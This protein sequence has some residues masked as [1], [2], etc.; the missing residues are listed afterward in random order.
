[1]KY[2]CLP[3]LLFA[4]V[5][6]APAGDPRCCP[7]PS[8][9][10]VAP[11][12]VTGQ[13]FYVLD[14]L[15]PPDEKKDERPKEYPRGWK[16]PT[17]EEIKRVSASLQKRHNHRVK[18][19][20][21]AA[22][23]AFDTRTFG[24]TGPV[25][26]QKNCGSCW[27][28]GTT[29]QITSAFIKAGYAKND[30]SFLLSQ[31][32]VL[33]CVPSG[34][35]NGDWGTTVLEAAKAKGLPTETDYGPYLARVAACKFKAG[36][37]LYQIADYGWCT[38][39]Q[40]WG[41]SSTQ[42]IKNCIVQ[43]GQVSTAV[44]ANSDWDSY[45]TGTLP[46]RKLTEWDVNHEVEICGW[47]DTKTVAGAAGKGAWLVKNSWSQAWGDKGYVWIGY[48]SHQI[49]TGAAWATVAALPPPPGPTP[50]DPP[51]PPVPPSPGKG[52][53]GTITKVQEYK[54]GVPVGPEKLILGAPSGI[55]LEAELKATWFDPAI[56]ADVMKLVN[57]F[58]EK[59]GLLVL[60]ADALKIATDLGLLKQKQDEEAEGKKSG[61]REE[62]LW[63]L[64]A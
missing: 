44:A 21:V 54:D 2:L 42:D 34:G 14:R 27:C 18:G 58:K 25:L 43:F 55:G 40:E 26:D 38:P 64:A 3:A 24:W 47:D 5:G 15:Q 29:D 12:V 10:Y 17:D 20:P 22:P 56:I 8:P 23:A 37:K 53:T 45:K 61:R 50:P 9:V 11:S 57:D 59:K 13:P 60:I 4:C 19:F 36:T 31:Q 16:R 6:L 33:D 49:G 32:Y 35:C 48:G 63:G 46:Y 7:A 28:F 41:I 52:Y 51:A 30:G 1:M 39:N 62:P